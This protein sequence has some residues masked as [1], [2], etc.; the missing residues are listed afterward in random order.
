MLTDQELLTQILLRMRSVQN[1][2]AEEAEAAAKKLLLTHRSI[3]AVLESDIESNI[4]IAELNQQS[5]GMLWLIPHLSRYLARERTSVTRQLN[6]YQKAAPFVRDLYTGIGM[7]YFHL[8]SLDEKGNIL[9]WDL[10]QQGTV[11]EVPFYMRR[12]LE[13]SLRR[14]A[15]AV[16][17]SHNHPSGTPSHSTADIACTQDAI[18]TLSPLGIVV[19][20]H[21]LV[22]DGRSYSLHDNVCF[23]EAVF[24]AQKP[25]FPLL[26]TWMETTTELRSDADD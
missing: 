3:G 23:P 11:D 14:N 20:D 25:D 12:I 24:L 17:L 2:T 9:G 5:A 22:A 26:Q 8:I 19:L 1:M 7:E 4:R 18:R 15:A 10:V 13:F 21:I 6:T 16:I